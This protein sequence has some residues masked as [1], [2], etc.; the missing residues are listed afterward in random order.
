MPVLQMTA[1]S[2][3]KNPAIGLQDSDQIAIFHSVHCF[4]CRDDA[5]FSILRYL[6]MVRRAIG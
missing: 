4:R 1:D 2:T 6:V 3:I 5:I